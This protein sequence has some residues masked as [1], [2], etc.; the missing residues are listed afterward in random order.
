MS[1][2]TLAQQR[3]NQFL[4]ALP[5]IGG[6]WF[7]T[8]DERLALDMPANALTEFVAEV[9]AEQDLLLAAVEDV[10]NRQIDHAGHAAMKLFMLAN[11]LST[12]TINFDELTMQADGYDLKAVAL[13]DG[14]V[15]FTLD[16]RAA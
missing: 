4:A 14:R 2:T 11:G 9:V 8:D 7:K 10:S 12:L 3:V 16:A 5:G 1:N 6:R 13:D 15:Q